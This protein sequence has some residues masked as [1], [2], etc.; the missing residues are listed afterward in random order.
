MVIC[1]LGERSTIM[2]ARTLFRTIQVL[3]ACVCIGNTISHAAI[4]E[5]QVDPNFGVG[6]VATYQWPESNAYQWDATDAWA[7]HLSNG[8]WAVAMRVRDGTQ[9]KIAVNWF[10]ANGAITPASPGAGPYTPFL[11]GLNGGVGIGQAL[12][13]SLTIA[14]TQF[15]SGTDHDFRLFRTN[16]DGTEGYA[17]CNG[18]F[19]WDIPFNLAAGADYDDAGAFTQDAAN[20]QIVA[21]TVQY[22]GGESRIGVS[23]VLPSCGF[24]GSFDLDGKQVVDPNP[25][26][27]PPARRTRANVV[28]SDSSQRTLIG[29]NATWGLNSTDTG[30]CIVVRLGVDGARDGSFGNNGVLYIENF[31]LASG[32]WICDI[33]GIAVQAD[34][35]IIVSGNWTVMNGGSNPSRNFVKRFD[36]NGNYDPGFDDCCTAGYASV[37]YH[38]GGLA[39]MEADGVVLH[40]DASHADLDTADA[41]LWVKKTSDGTLASTFVA[42][43]QRPLGFVSTSYHDVIVESADAFVVVATTGTDFLNHRNV[44]LIKYRRTSTIVFDRIFSDGYE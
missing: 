21:G 11:Q 4:Y 30:A 16:A 37:N 8:K 44:H 34:N 31:T 35:K 43:G 7:T 40:V 18:S 27:F 10:N 14:G 3:G 26:Q 42:Y 41:E 38:D 19:F 2:V 36:N 17:G 23:R 13:G 24:D 5:F 20:R 32:N 39:L 33:G 1:C 28:V 29:G 12:D 9:Q 15:P 6:G 22:P 25:F